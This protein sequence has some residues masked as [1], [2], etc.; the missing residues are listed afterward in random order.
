MVPVLIEPNPR[1]DAIRTS[2]CIQ[3]G[4]IIY[5]LEQ[6]DQP[7]LNLLDARVRADAPIHSRWREDLLGGVV[8]VE[9]EGQVVEQGIWED[10][11]YL[12]AAERELAVRPT[13]LTAV[14]Y[15]AWANR[16]PGAM[17]VWIPEQ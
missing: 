17:R 1:V 3:R 15:Y 16:S 12:P 14:P 5:C 10:H 7:D 11:L 9:V 8:T 6:A 4:P 2:L 13:P